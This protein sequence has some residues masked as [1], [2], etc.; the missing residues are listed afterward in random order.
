MTCFQHDLLVENGIQSNWAEHSS[1][2]GFAF[3]RDEILLPSF[4]MLQTTSIESPNQT[5]S[6]ILKPIKLKLYIKLPG[7]ELW[8]AKV[9]NVS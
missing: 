6:N 3:Y 5:Y 9:L 4:G 7:F 8:L 1:P 2:N